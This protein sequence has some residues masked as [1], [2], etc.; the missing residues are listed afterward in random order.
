MKIDVKT[1][2]KDAIVLI[3]ICC[4]IENGI[5]CQKF[6]IKSVPYLKET[7]CRIQIAYKCV[8]ELDKIRNDSSKPEIKRK[9][10]KGAIEVINVMAS[11]GLLDVRGKDTDSFGN[12]IILQNLIRYFVKYNVVLI[13]Q[14]RGLASDAE[15]INHFISVTSKKKIIVKNL[16][17]NGNIIDIIPRKKENCV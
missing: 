12:S 13:T 2:Y 10:A 1:L 11:E 8:Q 15:C 4:F 17:K 9:S 7:G 3:D 14:D 5:G 16:D 6:F